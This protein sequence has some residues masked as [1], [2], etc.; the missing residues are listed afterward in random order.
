MDRGL[1]PRAAGFSSTNARVFAPTLIEE[2]DLTVRERS[3]YQS[4]QHIDDAAELV[5]HSRPFVTRPYASL[6]AN[7]IIPWCR[8]AARPRR[9]AILRH[10]GALAD[11]PGFPDPSGNL[12]A[13][14]DTRRRASHG[15]VDRPL[16]QQNGDIPREG[17]RAVYRR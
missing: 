10:G 5:L 11:V 8:S 2:V 13:E 15:L 6:L 9:Y 1:L 14:F 3:P 16:K 7:A 12:T 4:W 17:L